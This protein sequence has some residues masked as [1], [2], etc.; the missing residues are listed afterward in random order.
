MNLNLGAVGGSLSSGE[1]G[2]GGGADGRVKYVGTGKRTGRCCWSSE[3]TIDLDAGSQVYDGLS[4]SMH[5]VPGYAK[6]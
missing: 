6:I 4:E 2:V 3:G 1:G 5:L